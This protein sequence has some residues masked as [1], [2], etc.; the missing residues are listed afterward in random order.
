M[1]I[2][3][4]SALVVGGGSLLYSVVLSARRLTEGERVGEAW[5]GLSWRSRRTRGGVL[6]L[7]GSALVI[8][9]VVLLLGL[10]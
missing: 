2:M 8:G 7:L 10:R 4:F 9:A 1:V 3:A 6:V 5:E